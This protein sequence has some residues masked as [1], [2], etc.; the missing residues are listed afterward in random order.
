MGENEDIENIDGEI[1]EKKIVTKLKNT[2]NG[3]EIPIETT[4]EGAKA[5]RDL[6]ESQNEANNSILRENAQLKQQM[7]VGDVEEHQAP[8]NNGSVPLNDQQIYG[9]IRSKKPSAEVQKIVDDVA[10]KYGLKEYDDLQ[11]MFE[12]LNKRANKDEKTD[13]V[14]EG[15]NKILDQLTF[16]A[17]KGHHQRPL[18]DVSI[19]P[20]DIS[21][22]HKN[23]RNELRKYH[24]KKD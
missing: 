4:V 6:I 22:Y 5:L 23:Q 2:V 3:V 1:E 13:V 9:T 10:V 8:I 16:K 17:I 11:S 21:D 20:K 24:I 14:D 18:I 12:D 15:V 19:D 7:A